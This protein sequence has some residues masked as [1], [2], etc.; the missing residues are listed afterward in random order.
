ML[1]EGVFARDAR[2]AAGGV[3]TEEAAT[4]FLAAGFLLVL[5]TPSVA[6]GAFLVVFFIGDLLAVVFF[7]EAEVVFVAMGTSEQSVRQSLRCFAIGR[8]QMG[9]PGRSAR[10]GLGDAAAGLERAS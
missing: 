4:F 6:A 2:L 9:P 5:S 3:A 10:Y 1:G 8:N 7:G